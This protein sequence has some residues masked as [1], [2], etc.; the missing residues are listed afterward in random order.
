MGAASLYL[1]NLRFNFA[2]YLPCAPDLERMGTDVAFYRAINDQFLC[3]YI[4]N[5]Q[6][7]FA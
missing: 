6:P 2:C 4:T 1:Q 7:F 5:D 3:N